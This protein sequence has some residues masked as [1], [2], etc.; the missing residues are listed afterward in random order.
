MIF[1]EVKNYINTK[2]FHSQNF[3]KLDDVRKEKAIENA[4]EMLYLM[5]K[6]YDPETNPLPISAIAYQTIWITNKNSAII[7][8][9][10]GVSSQSIEGMTQTFNKTDRTVAPEVKRILR[11]RV[12]SYSLRVADTHRGMYVR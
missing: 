6:A 5:Y 10:L 2:I 3:D 11:N 7:Q 12:G 8:A 4:E 9:D 1:E